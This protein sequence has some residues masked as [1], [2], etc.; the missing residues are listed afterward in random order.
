MTEIIRA[1]SAG[2]LESDRVVAQVIGRDGAV[3]DVIYNI[4]QK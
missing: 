4:P 2:T 3:Q 1:A